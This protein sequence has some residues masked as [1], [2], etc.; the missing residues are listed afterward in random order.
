MKMIMVGV[1]IR[2]GSAIFHPATEAFLLEMVTKRVP[3]AV[4]LRFES[5]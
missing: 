1:V 3:F 2:L 5:L 4:Q